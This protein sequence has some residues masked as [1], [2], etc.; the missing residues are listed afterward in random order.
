MAA[1][2][3]IFN[4]EKRERQYLPKDYELKGWDDLK[5]LLEELENRNITNTE[6]LERW[7]LDRSELEA[8]LGENAAWRYINYTRNTEDEEARKRYLYFVQE[9]SPKATPYFHRLDEKVVNSPF[10]GELNQ[11]QYYTYFRDIRKDIEIYREENIPLFTQLQ[12]KSQKY[13]E[14]AGRMTIEVEGKEYTL[15]Q[16]SVFL[17]R[18]DRAL[19]KEVYDK[20]TARRIEDT[21]ALDTLFNELLK[22]R[23]EAAHN[24]G[25]SNYRDYKYRELGRFDYGL[26]ETFQFH[27]AIEEEVVP[28]AREFDLERKEKLGLDT[29]RPYDMDVDVEGKPAIK[30]FET[31]EELVQKTITC[32]NAIDPFLGR[33]IATMNELGYLDLESR[34]GK[35]P[36]GYNYPLD[37]I[38]VPFIF[39]NSA[40]TMRD[41][42]TMVHEGGHAVHSFLTRDFRIT[43]QKHPPSEVA[44]LA[45]MSMELI[46]MEYW[47][48]FISDP[49][50]LRRAKQEQLEGVLGVLPWIAI[51]DAFQHWLYENPQHTTEERDQQWQATLDRF[52]TGV[53]DHSGYEDWRRKSWQRQLHIFEVPFYYIEYGIAQLGAISVWKNFVENPKR[54]LEQYKAALDLGFSKPIP[55]IYEAAGIRFDFSRDY[56]R[57]LVQFVKAELAEL[58]IAD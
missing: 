4:I 5:P 37:E 16:A 55:E 28:V 11:E 30:P 49:E 2:Q 25:F 10:L 1:E 29:L 31:S 44:E 6:E 23:H 14:I 52:S 41:V 32:F 54:G 51:V 57:E 12:E 27:K 48:H 58:E 40:G 38:G 20:V 15:P 33:C 3:Q 45:S 47:E 19:R 53:V 35:A 17:K 39:M 21:E 26:E 56:I 50:E 13:G 34:K 42:H 7:L 9:I 8:Y 43:F 36:G 24:A 18:H 22:L 46:S